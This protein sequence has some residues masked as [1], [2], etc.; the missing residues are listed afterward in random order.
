MNIP[1][2]PTML[3]SDLTNDQIEH[4]IILMRIEEC[5]RTLRVG[6]YV[7]A[8]KRSVSPEPTYDHNGKRSNTREQRYRKKIEDERHMLVELGLRTIVGFRPP[9][10]YSRGGQLS[11]KVYIPADDYPHINFI[12][13]LIGP[14][15]ST[16][17]K[18]ENETGTKISIRGR[19]SVKEGKTKSQALA[20]DYD[21]DLHCLITSDSEERIKSCIAMIEKIIQTAIDV[22]EGQNELKR[23]QLQVL[24][25]LNGTLKESEAVTCT[26][27]GATGHRRFECPEAV[28]F[29]SQLVCRICNSVGHLARDCLQKNDAAALRAAN[30]RD[31]ALD[32]E[33]N[34]LM[35]ELGQ[36]TGRGSGPAPTP[37]LSVDKDEPMFTANPYGNVG[38]GQYSMPIMPVPPPPSMPAPIPPTMAPPPP[39]V[40]APPPPAFVPAPPTDLP[41]P[42]PP[43]SAPPPPPGEMPPPPP[44]SQPPPP[45][46]PE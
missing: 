12:G 30:M 18:M 8:I 5:S 38:Y 31:Q 10:D 13:L 43:G 27:C 25:Q 15:G 36:S 6:D 4:Y 17:K 20:G 39:T 3:P 1:G 16:L 35:S 37:F 2:L 19:G 45:P 26:N 42:P 14:R 7:P 44:S 21:D 33:Y 46:P 9:I 23:T 32:D 29:T 40:M 11:E 28:N 41:P 34:Q 24:A 22:P